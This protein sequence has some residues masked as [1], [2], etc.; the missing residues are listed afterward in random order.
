MS[1]LIAYA[2]KYGFT[3]TCAQMLAKK[4]DEKVDICDLSS[5][6]PNLAQYDKVIIGGSIYAGRIRKPAARFCTE[7][8]STL[9]TKKLGLFICGMA[10][11]NDAQKQLESS[12]P[13]E[14]LS[15]AVVKDS[16]GGGYE[17]SKLNFLERFMMKKISGSDENQSRI[18]EEDMTRF[19][20]Q[21]K[22]S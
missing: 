20:D 19:A 8:L 7:N 1:I 13:K 6:R 4:L 12:F 10:E 15:V 14:M 5:N 18:M 11:G 16:F 9:K 2:T 17:F 22:N 3:K 21:M